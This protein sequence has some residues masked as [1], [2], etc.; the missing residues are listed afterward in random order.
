MKLNDITCLN[1]EVGL[2]KA[3]VT[4]ASTD[5]DEIKALILADELMLY[6]GIGNPLYE[7]CGY[8]RIVSIRILLDENASEVIFAKADNGIREV[9]ER[10]CSLEETVPAA[11]NAVDLSA[12]VFVSLAQSESLDDVTV[13]E[14]TDLFPEWSENFTGKAGTI[15]RV[16]EMLYRSI[17]DVGAGQNTNPVETPS[18]WTPLGIEGEEYPEWSQP[19]GVH[20]AYSEGDKVSHGGNRYISTV[21]DNVWEPGIYGWA[22]TEE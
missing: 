17:H 4:L 20:D 14:H 16:G 22:E 21:N 5:L 11:Q 12:I 13:M 3:V 1:Y 18:M 2:E 15:V 19:L 8:D 7:L 10:L 6:D 9:K